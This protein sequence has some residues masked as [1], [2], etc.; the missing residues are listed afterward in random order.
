MA[1]SCPFV[2]SALY[3]PLRIQLPPVLHM[4]APKPVHPSR[5]R[6]WGENINHILNSHTDSWYSCKNLLL[7][8]KTWEFFTF[9][10]MACSL[11]LECRSLLIYLETSSSLNQSSELTLGNVLWQPFCSSASQLSLCVAYA[12]LFHLSHVALITCSL[13]APIFVSCHLCILSTNRG[14]SQLTRLII[15][16][17]EQMDEWRSQARQM[18]SVLFIIKITPRSCN[19]LMSF[20][21]FPSNK[22]LSSASCRSSLTDLKCRIQNWLPRSA[23]SFPFRIT[24][25]S[26]WPRQK[27]NPWLMFHKRFF[28]PPRGKEA[29]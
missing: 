26:T 28:F 25:F 5:L 10:P 9:N 7:E 15:F 18:A 6:W 8:P 2:T 16:L 12:F 3:V 4:T 29:N 22:I 20:S 24:W 27:N 21:F 14:P 19:S 23:T 13:C 11:W 17:N 1:L